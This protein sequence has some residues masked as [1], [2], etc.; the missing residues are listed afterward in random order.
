M[1]HEQIDLDPATEY[2]K[3][4][5]DCREQLHQLSCALIAHARVARRD[6]GN[7][8]FVGDL[9]NISKLLEEAEQFLAY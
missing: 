3:R 9:G 5:R 8:E 6:P 4:L 1:E 7:W 2:A